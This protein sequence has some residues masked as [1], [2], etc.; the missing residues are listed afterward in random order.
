MSERMAEHGTAP[1]T[2]TYQTQQHPDRGGLP[3]AVRAE[4]AE[5]LAR[6]HL[7]VEAVDRDDVFVSLAE[8]ADDEGGHHDG[9]GRR[10]SS[11]TVRGTG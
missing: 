2:G 8:G 7:E 9:R 1:G 6:K 3:G 4:E 10:G 5:A 11:N